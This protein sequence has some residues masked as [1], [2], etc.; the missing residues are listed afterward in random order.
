MTSKLEERIVQNADSRVT[1]SQQEEYPKNKEL[2]AALLC[3]K[4]CFTEC[5]L[6]SD[7]PNGLCDE[8]GNGS[9]VLLDNAMESVTADA[10][11]KDE[12]CSFCENLS[13]ELDVFLDKLKPARTKGD[14]RADEILGLIQSTGIQ[15]P[16]SNDE[17]TS[18]NTAEPI[19]GDKSIFIAREYRR[20]TS[21]AKKH[22]YLHKLI[23]DTTQ[24]F[25][26]EFGC[27]HGDNARKT[28]TGTDAIHPESI[29]LDFSMTSVQLAMYPGDS[30]SGYRRHCD[31]ENSCQQEKTTT[32]DNVQDAVE[33]L[34]ARSRSTNP[35]RLITCIYYLTD[36]DWDASLD[37]GALRLFHSN[38][39]DDNS[40]DKSRLA[41]ATENRSL[42]GYTDVIPF[43]N[44]MV[45]FRSDRVPHQV[46]PSHRRPRLAIT[47]W[48]Y[49]KVANNIL[50]NEEDFP[51]GA[52]S[53]APNAE[54]VNSSNP[55]PPLPLQQ[56]SYPKDQSPSIFVSIASYR[57]SETRP[58]IDALYSM[59][60]KPGRIFTGIVVQLEHGEK[61]DED[62][63]TS[64]TKSTTKSLP[65]EH[66][67]RVIRIHARDATGPCYARG[68]C[69]TLY[70][71]EDYVLQID[72]HMRFRKNWDE[73]LIQTIQDI[74][75]MRQKM[76]HE[77][78]IK[79]RD[80]DKILLTTYPVGYT[81]PNNIP[82]ETRGTYLVPWKFDD[83]GM[84]RQR[85]RLVRQT[86]FRE[87]QRRNERLDSNA[88]K[89][90][91]KAAYDSSV[92]HAHRHYLYAGGFNFGPSRVIFDVPY[93]T[94]G[95]HQLFFGEE[96]SMAVRLFT[97]GYDLYA[98][99][100]S[101]CY[102]L[103]SRSHRPTESSIKPALT[104]TMKDKK[105]R[106]LSQ[107]RVKKQLL[108]DKEMIGVHCGLGQARSAAAFADRLGVSFDNQTF[109]REGWDC[110]DLN[111]RDF[112]GN[113]N[114]N[115]SVFPADSVEAKVASLDDKTQSL[116]GMF[117]KGM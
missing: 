38:D 57:D 54:G 49:G 81:L 33:R 3:W 90:D 114:G 23:S 101:V 27:S 105:L 69:Q 83:E 112:V 110:G 5:L 73:Y 2:P 85:G 92:S 45:V 44:R 71:D 47:M 4:A 9:F 78:E 56:I 76:S 89:L 26:R 14:R 77:E 107:A 11:Q 82:K 100:E 16:N 12:A 117:L 63:W 50:E 42:P 10:R 67:L 91:T 53:S 96:L 102:H 70:R 8:N 40:G 111:S 18:E 68:L 52:A 58:T 104:K 6:S 80:S 99:E 31:R 84:L 113:S 79:M 75:K 106:K 87:N 66:Q 19:R 94:M 86:A 35:E 61:Y 32:G 65:N 108:G 1:Q 41:N 109:V 34:A 22:P 98:P 62:I 15:L 28:S 74:Q 36:K 97:H 72:S 116:I 64:I 24:T 115:E 20:Q 29:H 59:A 103:W 93:D 88:D 39:G 95:L 43:R 37:G 17:S 21:F 46:M 60:F 7:G 30:K 25:E 55:F 51:L 48:F 13:R